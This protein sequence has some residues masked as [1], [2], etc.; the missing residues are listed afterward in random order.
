MSVP[1]P[2]SS[3]ALGRP[4]LRPAHPESFAAPHR[5]VSVLSSTLLSVLPWRPLL[6]VEVLEECVIAPIGLGKA[7]RVHP[8]QTVSVAPG[9]VLRIFMDSAIKSF[10][11][12][13]LGSFAWCVPL[14]SVWT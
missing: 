3:S 10:S 9:E 4:P 2:H 7:Q 11:G 6:V 13:A 8:L 1:T 5:S 12:I 14:S